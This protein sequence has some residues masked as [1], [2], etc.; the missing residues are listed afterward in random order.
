MA[1]VP[2]GDEIE[3]CIGICF[4]MLGIKQPSLSKLESQDD[5]HIST[6]IRIVD[7]LGGHLEIIAHLPK[8]DLRIGQFKTAHQ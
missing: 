3:E 1:V 5:M 6:L 8:G 4:K 2:L 7:A